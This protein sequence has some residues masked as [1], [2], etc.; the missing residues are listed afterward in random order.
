MKE[1]EQG[2]GD[3][4]QSPEAEREESPWTSSGNFYTD[5]FWVPSIRGGQRIFLT[6]W[7]DFKQGYNLFPD[8]HSWSGGWDTGQFWERGSDREQS[9]SQTTETTATQFLEEF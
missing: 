4:G 5:S 7:Y 2:R 3:P 1:N 6:N 9:D 8:Y